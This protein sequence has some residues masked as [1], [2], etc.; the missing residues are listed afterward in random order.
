MESVTHHGR[1]TVYR[2][3]DRGGDG[4][5]VLF[6]HGSGGTKDV[7]KSQLRI[8]DEYPVV[9][10]DL[11]GHG[12][13]DDANAEPGYETLSAY[14][15]DVLAVSEETGASVFVGNS[16]GGAVALTAVLQREASPDALV[17]AGAGA[18]LSVLDDLLAWLGD[19]FERA[20]EFLHE[21]DRLFHDASEKYVE[22]SREAMFGVGQAVTERDFLTCHGFDVR[23]KLD[24]VEVPTLALVGEHDKL[25]PRSYHEYFVREL[26]DCEL[27]VVEDAAHL[28]MLEEPTAFNAALT[29][30][31]DRRVD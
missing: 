17:L 9:T 8:A 29:E 21:P 28:A 10:L 30:F 19:D 16:L 6:V 26:P 3:A 25:T 7:W 24:D 13:S 4:P 15:D 31:L 1:E 18:K 2:T 23:G 22:Q 27:A 14:V 11:S 20:V 5:T 12:E